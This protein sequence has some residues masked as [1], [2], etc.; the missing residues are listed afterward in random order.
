MSKQVLSDCK[1]FIGGYDLT[2]ILN[3]VAIDAGVDL[4]DCTVFGDTARRRLPGLRDIDLKLDGYFDA[5]IEETLRGQLGL[6]DVPVTIAPSA[7]AAGAVAYGFQAAMASIALSGSVGETFKQSVSAHAS[8]MPLVRGIILANET[9]IEAAAGAGYQLGAVGAT[10]FVYGGLHVFGVDGDDTPD[11]TVKI[12]SDD[13]SGFTSATDRL[14]FTTAAGIFSEWKSL[15]GA[16]T[17]DYWR[18][19]WAVNGTDPSIP[20][21]VFCGIL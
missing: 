13:N 19:V 8:Q 12:Q 18:A 1:A 11:I 5:A 21:A 20:F 6:T 14:V 15:A 4:Q 2:G 16:V 17:D 3:G 10:Q 7:G 9:T